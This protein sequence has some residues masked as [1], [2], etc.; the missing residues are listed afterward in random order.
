MDEL[1]L[2]AARRAALEQPDVDTELG[3]ATGGAADAFDQARVRAVQQRFELREPHV[4]HDARDEA[5]ANGNAGVG[6]VTRQARTRVSELGGRIVVQL[7]MVPGYY[8]PLALN[9]D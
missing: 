5:E 1:F 2:P 7:K 3:A 9:R 4:V 6:E 8:E